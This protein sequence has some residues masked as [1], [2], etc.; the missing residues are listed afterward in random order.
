MLRTPLP[1]RDRRHA[2]PQLLS[3][4]Q[5]LDLKWPGAVT[6]PRLPPVPQR[7]GEVCRWSVLTHRLVPS[8]GPLTGT[9]GFAAIT[10]CSFAPC[11]MGLPSPFSSGGPIHQQALGAEPVPGAFFLRGTQCLGPYTC[12]RVSALLTFIA[13]RIPIPRN[14]R[15]TPG[16]TRRGHPRAL[17]V[18]IRSSRA[19]AWRGVASP[20]PA[21]SI[22]RPGTTH[23]HLSLRPTSSPRRCVLRDG[24]WVLIA[25]AKDDDPIC[26]RPFDAVTFSLGDL[27]S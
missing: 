7:S 5:F 26:I 2:L 9:P 3:D 12:R 10:H 19:R 25:S 20:C 23:R 22:H 18:F 4:A 24:E 1:H 13:S 16:G 8:R 11:T 17:H 14:G 27:W 21:V 15:V 6:H